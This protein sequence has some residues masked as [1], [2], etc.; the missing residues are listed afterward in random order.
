[1]S[2]TTTLTTLTQTS[3]TTL[4]GSSRLTAPS[5][6]NRDDFGDRLSAILDK[7]IDEKDPLSKKL[8]RWGTRMLEMTG[9]YHNNHEQPMNMRAVAD[10]VDEFK[11]KTILNAITHQP[12]QNPVLMG[13]QTLEEWQCRI[14]RQLFTQSPFDGTPTSLEPKLHEFAREMIGLVHTLQLSIPEDQPAN[15]QLVPAE[16]ESALIP[17][18]GVEPL[19]QGQMV[20][21]SRFPQFD[22]MRRFMFQQLALKALSYEQG[23]RL[24][25]QLD[26]AVVNVDYFMEQVREMDRAVLTAG[27][28]LSAAHFREL[29]ERLQGI[30][31]IHSSTITQLNEQREWMKQQHQKDLAG[32][33]QQI[34]AIGQANS[35]VSKT[36]QRQIE[37]MT[38]AHQAAE[39][40]LGQQIQSIHQ[41]HAY[42][43]SSL[44]T[45][46]AR[47]MS[48][49][50]Q[51][52]SEDV[53]R[54]QGDLHQANQRLGQTQQSLSVAQQQNAFQAAEVENLR[55]SYNQAQREIQNLH[56]KIND[57]DD[58][59]PISSIFKSLGL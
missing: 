41:A 39:S 10:M 13:R 31:R 23:E 57:M 19:D 22:G 55:N 3:E 33:D 24:Q 28:E 35:A 44:Q 50:R 14:Y 25:E 26:Q 53:Q 16:R 42:A 32:L 9:V 59:G 4:S 15:H 5:D 45:Q 7:F 54:V 8:Y 48:A 17:A 34:K 47:E 29:E 37:S 20:L 38:Q 51:Q 18:G 12:L 2:L 11:K 56:N 30:D 52:H 46:M 6:F 58:D 43:I 1:M 21:L 27:E 36:L 40:A 49:A